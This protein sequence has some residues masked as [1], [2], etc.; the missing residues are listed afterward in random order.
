MACKLLVRLFRK[1]VYFLPSEVVSIFNNVMSVYKA[2]KISFQ[3]CHPANIPSKGFSYDTAIKI[4]LL[5]IQINYI[6]L[7]KGRK[8]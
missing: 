3:T 5:A 2:I 6:S 8:V 1:G 7:F 4:V